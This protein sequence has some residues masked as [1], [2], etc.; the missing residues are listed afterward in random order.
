MSDDSALIA[1]FFR[2]A[3]TEGW[4]GATVVAAA[5]DADAPLGDARARFPSRGAVLRRFGEMADQAALSSAITD[6]PIR[7]RLFDLLMRR[8]DVLQAHRDGVLALLR[9]LPGDPPTAVALACATRRSMRW[10]LQAAGVPAAGLRGELQVRGLMAVWLWSVRAWER[11]GSA[12][13]SAT[14]AALDTALIRA[15]RVANWLHGRSA[16]SVVPP[17]SGE[18]AFPAADI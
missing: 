11:D 17:T 3:V 13:L 14:M 4:G 12:D 15:E 8:F 1:A 9:A 18:E 16:S 5:R 7:D 2:I 10:M 6:G